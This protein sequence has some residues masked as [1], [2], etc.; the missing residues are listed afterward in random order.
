[1]EQKTKYTVSVIAAF[2]IG[3]I[4]TICVYKYIPNQSQEKVVETITKNVTIQEN[5]TIASAV[6]KIYDATVI[7]ETY[8]GTKQI[9]S[10]T[11]FIYKKDENKGYIITNNHVISDG[12]NI[13]VITSEG[14][15]I[16]AQ[17]LGSDEYADIAV[18]S[19]DQNE[20]LAVAEIGES[21]TL[22]LGDTLFTV[23]TPVDKE[24][25]GTVTKGILS[26][27]DRMVTVKSESGGSMIME[28]LQTDA[29]INPGN[30]GGPLVNINGQVVGVNS[31]KLVEDK[32]EGMGFAIPIETA[33]G[34]VER[35][36]IGEKIVRPLLGVELTDIDNTYLLYRNNI[37]IP[38]EVEG[39]VVIISVSQGSVAEIA[40]LQKGDIIVDVEGTTINTM[41]HFRYMLYKYTVG[42]QINIKY[43]RNNKIK[44][45]TLNLT[46][47]LDE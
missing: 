37:D 21:G 23:G 3:V 32:I 41:A 19:I 29:A 7:V 8:Q 25:M 33:M 6:E 22:R 5:D 15:T 47:G 30:S 14:K 12:D 46:I 2:F 43:I 1:M 20:V 44:E 27:K 39:G 34:L 38:E 24:Y 40:G 4:G 45:A 26:G 9:S 42:D 35:L 16:D 18:V 36:E 31:L 11:G 13:K 10:G 28:V 17:L